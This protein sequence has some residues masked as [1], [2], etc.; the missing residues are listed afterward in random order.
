MRD[1]GSC[2]PLSALDSEVPM[3]PGEADGS[4]DS[5][6][7]ASEREATL[8]KIGTGLQS[9]VP[10]LCGFHAQLGLRGAP[11]D[12]VSR[13]AHRTICYMVTGLQAATLAVARLLEGWREQFS[14]REFAVLLDVL[15][16]RLELERDEPA[17]KRRAA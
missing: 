5:R 11:D 16:R 10:A 4:S 8:A 9:K 12:R 15:G 7:I 3:R 2:S 6:S 14:A 1:V 13:D 17:R